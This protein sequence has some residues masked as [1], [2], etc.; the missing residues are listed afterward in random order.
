MA[1]LLAILRG[2]GRGG[3]WVAQ[4]FWGIAGNGILRVLRWAGRTLVR[5]GVVIGTGWLIYWLAQQ[6]DWTP[7]SR[8]A[9][10]LL[11]I[12]V[13]VSIPLTVILSRDVKKATD[14]GKKVSEKLADKAGKAI[15]QAIGTIIC[16]VFSIP[17]K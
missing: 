6:M 1:R 9:S 3:L 10:E 17:T 2:L 16:W 13:V 12:A 4:G 15:L 8:L 7:V 11:F 5:G 14:E